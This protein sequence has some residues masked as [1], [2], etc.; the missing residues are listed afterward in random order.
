V[1][2]NEYYNYLVDN[3]KTTNKLICKIPTEFVDVYM[4][5]KKHGFTDEGLDRQS[6][7]KKGKILDRYILGMTMKEIKS[8][9]Q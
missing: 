4:F 7:K 8:W 3:F 1:L 2:V 5:A 6:I 9:V